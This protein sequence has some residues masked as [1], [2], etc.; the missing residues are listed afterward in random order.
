MDVTIRPATPDEL[1]TM[2]R[3]LST[4]FGGDM[5]PDEGRHF[6]ELVELER[7]RCAFAGTEMVATLGVLSLELAVP[8]GSLP[9]AGTTA[10]SVRTSHRRRGV[11]RALMRSHLEEARGRADPL[12][13]LWA[14][15]SSIYG[16]FGFGCAA[17]LWRVELERAHAG[18]ARPIEASGACRPI[19][20]DEAA[21]L[22]PDVYEAEWRRRPGQFARPTRFWTH[23]NL[24]DLESERRGASTLRFVVY[25]SDGAARGYAIFRVHSKWDG[26][27]L[28]RGSVRVEEHVGLDP[29]A[30]AALW[31]YLLDVDLVDKLEVW[32]VPADSELFSLVADRRRVQTTVRD[33]LWVRVLDVPAALEG[34][35][36]SASGSL[37]FALRDPSWPENDGVYTLE[38]EA[39]GSHCRRSDDVAQFALDAED[40]GAIY[41]GGRS[42]RALARAGRVTGSADAL[43]RA[44]AMFAWDP[45]P[46]CPEVF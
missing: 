31:R 15:E 40:L 36:Y 13:A 19:D 35:A 28:H 45:A 4:A 18:F 1:P 11:L 10:V 29:E 8:G 25:E 9:T 14:S 3:V 17:D 21:K 23:R 38:A 41:M 26:S 44:D 34:R 12:A 24:V 2:R 5:D 22:L 39:N 16:R 37:T 30:R 46:H 7:T 33:S 43:A 32:A 42:L 6:M 20:A 27:G